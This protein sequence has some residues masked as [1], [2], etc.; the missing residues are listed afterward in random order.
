MSVNSTV[1]SIRSVA[2][3]GASPARN[4][5]ASGNRPLVFQSPWNDPS[6]SMNSAD[7]MCSA[8]QRPSSIGTSGS[9]CVCRTSVGTEI[10]GNTLRT[11]IAKLDRMISAT[12]FGVVAF[13]HSAR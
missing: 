7:G 3:G 2:D 8:S 10:A 12:I 13:A 6:N 1:A 9:P 5:A 11:S 4:D